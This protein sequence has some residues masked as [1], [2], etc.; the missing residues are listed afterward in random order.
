MISPAGMGRPCWQ[1][2]GGKFRDRVRLYA[3]TT[4]QPTE[5]KG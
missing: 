5:E 1:M 4:K 3:D 2:L